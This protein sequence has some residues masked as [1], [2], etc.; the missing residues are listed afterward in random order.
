MAVAILQFIRE[1]QKAERPRSSCRRSAERSWGLY[2]AGWELA[3]YV[4]HELAGS[5]TLSL[6]LV[7][8]GPVA[9]SLDAIWTALALLGI[10]GWLIRMA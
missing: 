7:V 2:G 4:S 5:P 3:R 10:A 1:A 9:L 8:T 6:T